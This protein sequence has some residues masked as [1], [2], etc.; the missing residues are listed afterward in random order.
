MS[1]SKISFSYL[2]NIII[3]GWQRPRLEITRKILKKRVLTR[4]VIVR[5]KSRCETEAEAAARASSALET[6]G[7]PRNIGRRNTIAEGRLH[8]APLD[9]EGGLAHLGETGGEPKGDRRTVLVL[10]ASRRLR[11]RTKSLKKNPKRSLARTESRGKAEAL[12]RK[13]KRYCEVCLTQ[14]LGYGIPRE[15]RQVRPVEHRKRRSK[16]KQRG[17]K[18]GDGNRRKGE[19]ARKSRRKAGATTG[20]TSTRDQTVSRTTTT[21]PET[22]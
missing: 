17:R 21:T 5:K 4:Q 9:R 12:E 10:R 3:S 6:G 19:T 11:S 1:L 20:S 7:N 13:K 14:K 22:R 15:A 16:S 8:R 2:I 18:V